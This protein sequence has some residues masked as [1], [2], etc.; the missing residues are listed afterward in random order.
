MPSSSAI[1]RGANPSAR[2]W[3]TSHWRSLSG[4]PS[5][6]TSCRGRGDVELADAVGRAQRV[7]P[8]HPG[9]LARGVLASPDGHGDVAALPG[10]DADEA[11]PHRAP[12][13]DGQDLSL[14]C[15]VRDDPRRSAEA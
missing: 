1:W 8:Q 13:P 5:G 9:P 3:K 6:T 11:D 10:L 4:Q 12:G 15:D 2:S 14:G 7:D